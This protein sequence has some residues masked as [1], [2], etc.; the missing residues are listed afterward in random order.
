MKYCSA[1]SLNNYFLF[2][3][4]NVGTKEPLVDSEGYPRNDIDVYQV[5]IAR[6]KLACEEYILVL[7]IVW[8]NIQLEYLGLQN[9]H[10]KIMKEIED[11][12]HSIHLNNKPSTSND[13]T[14]VDVKIEPSR[15]PFATI[16]IVSKN[17][18]SETAVSEL[19]KVCV[20][21]GGI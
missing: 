12:I 18:P 2:Q 16:N 9:D 13:I 11:E 19:N 21:S 7:A 5:R 15:Q 8:F 17:S 1:V 3:Q 10:K 6:N 14:M 20:Y 4:G